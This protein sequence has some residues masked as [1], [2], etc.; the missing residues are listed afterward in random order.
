MDNQQFRLE[1]LSASDKD[2]FM[3]EAQAAFQKGFED[4]YGKTDDF[5]LPLSDIVSSFDC[6]G[7]IAYKAILDGEM[8]GGAIIV[9]KP[10]SAYGHLD[11]LY[12]KTETQSRGVGK[13]IWQEIER[14]HPEIKVWETCTPYFDKRNIHF[15]VNVCGFHIVEFFNS[16]HSEPE[17]PDNFIGDGGEGMFRFRKEL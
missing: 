1:I 15:Y 9:I 17:M 8:M 16:H 3:A 7:S 14:L 10:E 13:R 12:V 4:Y 6:K 5:V 11:L 2:I